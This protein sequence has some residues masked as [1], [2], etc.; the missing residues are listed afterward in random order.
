[1]HGL[2]PV[3]YTHLE[4]HDLM[5]FVKPRYGVVTSVGPQHLATFGSMDNILHEKMQMIECLPPD[6]TGFVNRDNAYIQSYTIKNK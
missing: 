2:V 5:Q 3:S 1:M 6:G 4:I